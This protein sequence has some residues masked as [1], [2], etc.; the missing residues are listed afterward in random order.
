M[1]KGVIAGLGAYLLWG[2]FPIYWKWLHTV[3]APQILAHRM[4]WSLIFVAG[5]MAL[6]HDR[7][8]LRQVLRQRKTLLVYTLAAILLSGN[9][10]GGQCWLHRR[11]Q[12]GLLHQSIGECVDGGDFVEGKTAPQ[13]GSSSHP[14][15]RWSGLP[16]L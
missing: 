8:W 15:W 16:Y 5:V 13:A 6:Q 1:N 2:V 4:V 10:L 14:G 11:D 9:H 3:P 7:D 12:P